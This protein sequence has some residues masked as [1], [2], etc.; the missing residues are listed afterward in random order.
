M[1]TRSDLAHLLR[2]A[3]F[4]PRADE[5]DAAEKAGVA[6]TVDALLTDFRSIVVPPGE[7]PEHTF[8]SDAAEPRLSAIVGSK[9]GGSIFRPQAS[10]GL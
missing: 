6:A 8:M 5:V 7:P 4:G 10:T 1:A 2:R 9:V 3:G